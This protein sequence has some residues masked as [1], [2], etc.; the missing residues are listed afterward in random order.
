MRTRDRSLEKQDF[1]TAIRI[2]KAMHCTANI[3]RKIESLLFSTCDR[4]KNNV[5]WRLTVL[6]ISDTMEQMFG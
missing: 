1:D 3:K 2:R 5:D 4:M 6:Q